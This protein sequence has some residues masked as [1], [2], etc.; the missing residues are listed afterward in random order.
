M[1]DGAVFRLLGV[2]AV[3]GGVLRVASAFVPW[4][5]GVWWLEL[6]YLAV[7]LSLL[8]G[9]MGVYFAYR[10]KV[11][12]FGLAA[13][14]IAEAGIASI[15]GPDSVAFGI[16]TYLMGVHIITVGL[17]L[18][19]IQLLVT[20]A[21]PWVAPVWWIGS[22]VFGAGAVVAGNPEIGFMVGGIMFGL[23]FV[24]AGL[25]FLRPSSSLTS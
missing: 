1:N 20:R 4:A 3:A 6:L 19:A 14:A 21:G 2:A 15:V 23:G 18:F 22:A 10:A 5:P 11:G 8:F 13:F 17:T 9:L 16:D 25:D 24:A 7:D 12:L